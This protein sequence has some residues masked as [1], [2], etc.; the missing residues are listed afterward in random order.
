MADRKQVEVATYQV[1]KWTFW[2]IGVGGILLGAYIAIGA[3]Q[4]SDLRRVV[5]GVALVLA[6]LVFVRYALKGA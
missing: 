2:L 4:L 1:L 5:M 6:G 3:L